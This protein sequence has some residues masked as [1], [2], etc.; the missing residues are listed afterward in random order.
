MTHKLLLLL[1]KIIPFKKQYVILI[2]KIFP[3]YYEP[4]YIPEGFFKIKDDVSGKYISMFIRSDSNIEREIFWNGLYGKWEKESL[5]IWAH[6]SRQANT[7]LD[8]G[9]NTGIFS[10]LAEIQNTNAGIYAIE[11]IDVNYEVL[12]KN[13]K[14]NKSGIHPIRAALSNTSGKAKM[15]MIKDRLN[16]M[17]SI[18]D[19]RYLD[20]PQMPGT[21]EV[22]EVEVSAITFNNIQQQY[23]IAKLDL[24][25]ID[26]EGH[27]VAVLENM[28]QQI[29]KDRP[30]ILTEV[31]G[32]ENAEALN[33][34]FKPLG[35]KFISIDEQKKSIEVDSL[36]NN[37]HHNFLLCGQKEIDA[38]RKVNLI[39]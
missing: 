11:P 29:I 38:L 1:Y 17:T 23:A 37:N 9:A 30:V 19:N 14:R 13:I 33:S 34:M 18:N 36:W 12:A 26:V 28:Y 20:P 8:I 27:E 4:S 35:Y 25:K 22:I 21:P 39:N 16:Y 32:D 15:Y 5:K 31:M 10:L 7:I 6:L 2:K 24:L 3:D